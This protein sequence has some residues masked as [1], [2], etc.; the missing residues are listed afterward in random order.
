MTHQE[1]RQAAHDKAMQIY[2]GCDPRNIDDAIAD[3]IKDGDRIPIGG[4]VHVHIAA[5]NA[6]FVKDDKVVNTV[7]LASMTDAQRD[8]LLVCKASHA[9][10]VGYEIM[11]KA[12]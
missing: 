3:G 2:G 6:E 11:G 5:D 8:M 4:G 7:P 9:S 12:V 10:R 1:I